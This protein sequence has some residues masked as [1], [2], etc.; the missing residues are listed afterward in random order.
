MGKLPTNVATVVA[1][2]P[3]ECGMLVEPNSCCALKVIS[4]VD[5]V[6]VT[7]GG[8]LGNQ[9]FMGASN[10]ITSLVV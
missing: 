1:T 7:D 6:L 5:D 3:G 9:D 4:H 10:D 2:L 8:K